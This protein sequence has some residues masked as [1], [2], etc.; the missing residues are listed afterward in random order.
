MNSLQ[1]ISTAG[2]GF[3]NP[4]PAPANSLRIRKMLQRTSI[5]AEE[6][7]MENLISQTLPPANGRS[8][9]NLNRKFRN[10]SKEFRNRTADPTATLS[11]QVSRLSI[12][13]SG[14]Q[15]TK[16]RFFRHKP[17]D[18]YQPVGQ[19]TLS[20]RIPPPIFAN[21]ITRNPFREAPKPDPNAFETNGDIKTTPVSP[22]SP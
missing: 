7:K 15:P 18:P 3:E 9:E 4:S 19:Q 13:E 11:D 17:S 21:P 2:A 14:Y 22:E 10:L 6:E 16:H 12:G 1:N 20:L 5:S 8:Y